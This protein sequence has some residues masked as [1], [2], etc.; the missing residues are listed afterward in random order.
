MEI[1]TQRVELL[2]VAPGESTTGEPTVILTIRPEPSNNFRP[3]NIAISHPQAIR[4]FRSLRTVLRQSASVLLLGLSLSSV[5]GCSAEVRVATEKT[6]PRGDAETAPPATHER[7]T[8]DVAVRLL[9]EQKPSPVEEPS[10]AKPAAAAPRPDPKQ[11]V[12][13]IGDGNAVLVVEGDLHVH[14][15]RHIH[16]DEAPRSEHVQIEIRRHE[17]ERDERCELLHREYEEKVRQLQRLFYK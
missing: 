9:D 2:S 14:E 1:M 4:L 12:E 7:T 16:I 11:G 13:I 10:P 15:H 8:T 5:A 17:A 3:H 6:A